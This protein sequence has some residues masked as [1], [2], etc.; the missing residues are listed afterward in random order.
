MS[1]GLELEP[2][3]LA[4]PGS[5]AARILAGDGPVALPLPGRG[6]E[7]VRRPARLGSDAFGVSADAV[8]PKLE[9]VL[10]GEGFVVTTG[11]QPVLFLGPL[12]VVYKA[13]TAIALADRL[14]RE[15]DA[16]VV[17]VFWIA[18]DDHDWQEIGRTRVIDRQNRLRTL[19]IEA[20]AGHQHRSAGQAPLDPAIEALIDELTEVLPPSEF[21]S[22]YLERVRE[23]Y[24]P[25]AT[26]SS[27]FAETLAA[28][29]DGREYAW[30]EAVG[31]PLKRGAVPFF[32]R[33]IEAPESV[34]DALDAGAS[35]PE[36]A[37]FDPP[38]ARLSGALPLFY[39]TGSSRERLY[40]SADGLSA[41]REGPVEPAAVWR[42]RLA[43][44]ASDFSPNV[45][46]RPVLE[47]F[48]L[49]VAA[50]VLGPG[51]VAYWSQLPPLFGLFDVPVPAIQARA[52]FTVIEPRNRELLERLELETDALGD[53]GDAAV[54]ALTSEARPA[55]V[56]DGLSG[57]RRALGEGL[58]G[59]EDAI[60]RVFP[61]LRASIGKTRKAMFDA[62]SELEGHV[63]AE[64]R[65]Q[66]ET[67]IDQ[68]RRL[69]THLYPDGRPQE[70]VLSPFY[71]LSRYGDELV[72][73]AARG[74]AAWLER[75]P[76]AS[77][78]EEG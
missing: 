71:H 24:R 36:E 41:G 35:G 78:R 42:E 32:E 10:A 37:G 20:P 17:P 26:V 62:M 30:L 21:V 49:P 4:E 54:V 55:A 72:A 64:V 53:G 73:A 33:M 27:A 48:L 28:V 31:G 76:L 18:G 61:G 40:M 29:L 12:Y 6:I 70:R 25:G 51:E 14:E 5:L 2:R 8:R 22:F 16:P 7:P 13:L 3:T 50:T 46:S 23:A 15:L 44:S 9:R 63:D 69:A 47:S 34:L 43:E 65:R 75:A 38:I 67:R 77:P 1:A 57:L 19:A 60:R 52:A 11:Q 56:E 66:Q 59:A 45:S 39:D 58:S 68:I 74:T